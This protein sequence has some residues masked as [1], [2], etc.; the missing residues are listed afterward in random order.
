[1]TPTW[2]DV[3]GSRLS[4]TAQ[5]PIDWR[6]SAWDRWLPIADILD[7]SDLITQADDGRCQISRERICQLA[8]VAADN[9]DDPR[10]L[11]AMVA[12][13]VVWGSGMGNRRNGHQ[14]G[15][16]RGPWRAA[17][18]LGVARGRGTPRVNMAKLQT[19]V[20]VDGLSATVATIRRDG[21]FAG[22]ERLAGAG[23]LDRLGPAFFTKIIYAVGYEQ[24]P[25]PAPLILDWNVRKALR[26]VLDQ[27]QPG[28]SAR[29]FAGSKGY[30]AYLT[31][32]DRWATESGTYTP[33]MIEF[34][35]FKTGLET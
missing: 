22:Y 10:A 13:T 32:V 1:M 33:E 29:A 4:T 14:I 24:C 35:L 2:I 9:P 34:A 6:P 8:D 25:G 21:A 26:V 17:S 7:E 19:V 12:S 28:T 16:P 27:V 18:A 15:D 30:L 23:H 31:L 11:A 20:D 3:L 5:E